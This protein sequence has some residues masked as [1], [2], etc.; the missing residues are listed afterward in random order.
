MGLHG[1]VV[2]RRR[3]LVAA[4][5]LAALVALLLPGLALAGPPPGGE[6]VTLG[7]SLRVTFY[8]SCYT[9]G[10][11]TASGIRYMPDADIVALGPGLLTQVR[12]HY[13]A[14]AGK[15]G[16]PLWWYWA[17]GPKLRFGG[18]AGGFP[19][20][21]C[22]ACEPTWWGYLVRV[23]DLD[24]GRCALL[25]LADTGSPALEVDLPD[26]IWQ[27]FGYPTTQGVFTGTLEVV[28]WR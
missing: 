4:F 10:E 5:G 19:R 16:Q 3:V 28:T 14:E 12:A 24:G 25:R 8:G 13:A 17:P 18:V 6:W 26:S 21:A 27:R 22:F 7:A 9:G 15:L 23:C 20:H 1:R 2:F 11:V